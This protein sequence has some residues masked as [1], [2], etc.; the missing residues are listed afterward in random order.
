MD[1]TL[2]RLIDELNLPSPQKEYKP[3]TVRKYKLDYAWPDI[4][5]GIELNG[6]IFMKKG[7]H[8]SISGLLRDYERMNYLQILGWLIIQFDP[9]MMR[10]DLY[11]KE[12]ITKALRSRGVEI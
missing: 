2:L 8:N 11:V 10:N 9:S 5:V 12:V 7:G 4:K 6:G 3:G 1:K